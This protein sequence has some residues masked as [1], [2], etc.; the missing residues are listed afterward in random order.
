MPDNQDNTTIVIGAG[1]AGLIAARDLARAGKSVVLLEARSRIGGRIHTFT[2]QGFSQP[3]EAG[4]EFMHGEVPLTQALLRGADIACHDTAGRAYAVKQGKAQKS[5]EFIENMPLL[6][7][8]LQA[9]EHDMPLL[10]FLDEY[11]P[12]D[13]H[14]NLRDSAIRFA[15]GY[16]AADAG[17]ASTFALRDE[18]TAGGAE[19]SPRPEGGYGRLIELLAQQ[20]QAAGATIQLSTVAQEIRWQRGKVEVICDQNRRYQAQQLLVTVP[21]GVLQATKG[22]P[23][24]LR[25][26]PELPEQRAAAAAMGFGPV[27]KILLEFDEA[28]WD[29][30]S[31]EVVQPTPEMG[32][33]FSD[34][35]VPTWWSQLPNPQPLLTGWLG[36][37]AAAKLH[38]AS[39]EDIVNQSLESLAYCFQTTPEFLRSHLRGQ[40]VINWGADPFARGAYAYATLETASARPILNQPLD[41]TLYFAGE[42]LYE[43]PA[44]GTVEAALGSGEQAAKL[45]LDK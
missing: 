9:L 19:D 28:F 33:L 39:A 44:M 8:T 38:D 34:A 23:G 17:R 10:D 16:D 14:H 15:E 42:A 4:A 30:K 13:R 32:F 45:M 2:G 7:S 41:N 12:D 26:T 21:L 5:E 35:P 18:W 40:Q 36:G 11:F 25:F 37:P 24:Y 6:L 22:Q 1:A 20:A 29:A 27:I 31:A 43:G 3:T